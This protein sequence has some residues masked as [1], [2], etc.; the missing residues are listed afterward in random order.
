MNA[1]TDGGSVWIT[2]GMMRFVKNENEL[3]LVLAHEMADA[4]LGRIDYARAKQVLEMALGIATDMLAAGAARAV[5][6]LSEL[7]TKKFDRDS[8]TRGG[9]L[10]TDLGASFRVRCERSQR[11]MVQDGDRNTGKCGER[12]SF[13]ASELCEKISLH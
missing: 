8:G 2:R 5:V 10:W 1:W 3:A 13:C 7:A 6:L 4:Y 11:S 12:I 9:S